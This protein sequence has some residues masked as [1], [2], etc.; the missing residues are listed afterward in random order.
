MY[1]S[2]S[3]HVPFTQFLPIVTACITVVPCK[4]QEINIVT[5]YRVYS[6]LTVHGCVCWGEFYGISLC[7]NLCIHNHYQNTEQ[8][9]FHKNSS[10]CPFITTYTY[11]HPIRELITLA[12]RVYS[13]ALKYCYVKMWIKWNHT[14]YNL[15][16]LTFSPIQHN[17]LEIHPNYCMCQ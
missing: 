4:N 7:V 6:D 1:S 8:F 11:L 14:I 10:C 2:I 3:L 16:R 12:L 5:I 15:L 13:P 9:H 17:S